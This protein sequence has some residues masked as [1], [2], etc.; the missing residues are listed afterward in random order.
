[1][2]DESAPRRDYPWAGIALLTFGALSVLFGIGSVVYAVSYG[3]YGEAIFMGLL[4]AWIAGL[5]AVVV[6]PGVADD[7]PAP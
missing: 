3:M 5:G 2:P 1:M 7:W 4:T 6:L